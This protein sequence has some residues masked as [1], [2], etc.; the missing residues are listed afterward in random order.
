MYVELL[1]QETGLIAEL[2]TQTASTNGRFLEIFTA[3][4][5]SAVSNSVEADDDRKDEDTTV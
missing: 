5:T 1:L 4:S 2:K 3:R